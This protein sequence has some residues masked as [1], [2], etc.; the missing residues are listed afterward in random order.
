MERKNR[1]ISIFYFFKIDVF[2]HTAFMVIILTGR[3][4]PELLGMLVRSFLF[5]RLVHPRG[6]F[7]E[8]LSH[9]LSG[10]V[11]GQNKIEEQAKAQIKEKG[12]EKKT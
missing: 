6:H 8:A 2:T 9:T 10:A 11:D 1:E 7:P 5:V 3:P 4:L 12:K